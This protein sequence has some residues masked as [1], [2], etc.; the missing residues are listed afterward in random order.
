[1]KERIIKE[2]TKREISFRE[3]CEAI[4]EKNIQDYYNKLSLGIAGGLLAMGLALGTGSVFMVKN[5]YDHYKITHLGQEASRETRPYIGV[6]Y[7]P[8][9]D[10]T[11][12]AYLNNKH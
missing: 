12:I 8:E 11:E 3:D 6:R 4:I 7:N 5:Y 10:K 9:K 2:Q 1:M